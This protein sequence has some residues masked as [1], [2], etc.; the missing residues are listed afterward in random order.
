MNIKRLA[1][2][3]ILILIIFMGCSET[4]GKLKTQSESNLKVTQQELND[5]WSDYD[6][7]YTVHIMVFDPKNDDKKI[8]V[9]N[10]WYTVKDQEIYENS[11]QLALSHSGDWRN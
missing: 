6:I 1:G 7:S 4:N 9:S 2:I 5:N 11:L 3:A 10:D 8:L